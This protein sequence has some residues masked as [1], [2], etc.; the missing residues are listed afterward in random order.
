M[1]QGSL[2]MHRPNLCRENWQEFRAMAHAQARWTQ[3]TNGKCL[4]AACQSTSGWKE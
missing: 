1:L 4:L 2:C 3:R